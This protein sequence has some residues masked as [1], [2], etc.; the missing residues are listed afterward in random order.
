M[1]NKLM[2]SENTFRVV[3]GKYIHNNEEL[4]K[5]EFDKR[6][7]E[8]DDAMRTIRG[9]SA[10]SNR[11]SKPMTLEERKAKSFADIDGM[12]NGGKVSSASFRADG[13]AQRGKTKGRMI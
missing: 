2:P 6:K 1:A 13:C 11:G 4:S 12:K 9:S 3:D 8:T 7:A 5:A 10:N